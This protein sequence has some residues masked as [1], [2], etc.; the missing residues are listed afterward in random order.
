MLTTPSRTPLVPFAVGTY[1]IYKD[2]DQE[3]NE[4]TMRIRRRTV[5]DSFS[6]GTFSFALI[7]SRN[8]VEHRRSLD[9]G[10][11]DCRPKQYGEIDSSVRSPATYTISLIKDNCQY[12]DELDLN[13]GQNKKSTMD[14][15]I[16]LKSGKDK[17]AEPSEFE[18]TMKVPAR[19]G[20]SWDNCDHPDGWYC[21]RVESAERKL[22][23]FGSDLEVTEYSVVYRSCPADLTRAFV[24]GVGVT[25]VEYHHHGTIEEQDRRLIDFQIGPSTGCL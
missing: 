14:L 13:D 20:A 6:R 15:W 4:L 23:Q 24:P 9:T 22:L 2:N 5:L 3:C 8:L 10:A 16:A 18:I 25:K 21:W 12:Y 19:V 11:E 7:E 17:I 1:W